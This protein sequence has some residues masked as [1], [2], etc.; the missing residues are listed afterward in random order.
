M[1]S[2]GSKGISGLAVAT[3]AIGGVLVW[4]GIN[5]QDLVTSIRYLAEGKEIPTGPQ[6][7][8]AF[9]PTDR[10]GD[11]VAKPTSGNAI[12]DMAA[13]YEGHPYIFGGGH[14]TVCPSTGMDCSGFVSCVLN[15]VG[16]MRGTKTTTGFASWGIN[17]P[18]EDRQPGDIIVWVGGAGNGH[19]GIIIDGNTMWHNPCTGCGGVQKGIYKATRTGRRTIVR[20][21][22]GRPGG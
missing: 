9:R 4:S 7:K 20:R 3:L 17:I 16:V 18:F 6:V 21:A 8:S 2:T 11:T 5:N 19:M 14:A 13:S 22:G 1:A 15:K 10:T 12:V